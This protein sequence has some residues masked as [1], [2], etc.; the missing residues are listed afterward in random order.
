MY[1]TFG[2]ENLRKTLM[3]RIMMRGRGAR[4]I[5][6]GEYAGATPVSSRLY[7]VGNYL[8]FNVLVHISV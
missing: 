7:K 5:D 4:R 2:M 1:F 6:S 3:Q 8:C